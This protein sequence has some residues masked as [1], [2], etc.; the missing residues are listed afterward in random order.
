MKFRANLLLLLLVVSSTTQAD[1]LQPFVIDSEQSWIRVL[2]YRTGLFSGLGH[3]HVIA[4]NDL[5][6][7]VQCNDQV[8]STRVDLSFP[9]ES[10]V[11]D[12]ND[13]RK[14]EGDDFAKPVSAKDINSTRNNML[15]SKLL[16][17]DS[18]PLI[19]I[20]TT[21]VE[22][23]VDSLLVTADMTVAGHTNSISFP[24]SA[25]LSDAQITIS[26]NA[27]ITHKQLGLKRFSAAF[28]TLKVHE[29]ITVRFEII[30]VPVM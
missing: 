8:A 28:G 26:G 12:L 7:T 6:G 21:A 10:L 29:D 18:F 25:V 24:A 22:G 19:R 27:T 5:S 4:S 14:L 3:N 13:N 11:V 15:G 2:V 23:T 20:Q 17:A 1:D 30:A 9:V 16:A